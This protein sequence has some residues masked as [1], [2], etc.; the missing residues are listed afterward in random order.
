MGGWY[1]QQIYGVFHYIK[2]SLYLLGEE[3]SHTFAGFDLY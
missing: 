1:I 3:I 2:D